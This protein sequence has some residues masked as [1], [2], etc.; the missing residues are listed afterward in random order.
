MVGV[1]VHHDGVDIDKLGKAV[2]AASVYIAGV[3]E[4]DT[5]VGGGDHGRFGLGHLGKFGGKAAARDKG[6]GAHDGKLGVDHL[7]RLH[8]ER[9]IE[10]AMA[11]AQ[12]PAQHD[13]IDRGHALV[14]II[15]DGD[16]GRDDRDAVALIEQAD[17]LERRG[18]GVDEHRVAVADELDGA[19]GN[20][21]L[22]GNVDVNTPVL[23]GD[24]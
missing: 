22:G 23:R 6:P 11:F 3:H 20:G 15:G 24:G 4:G 2:H 14:N 1:A 12:R 7:Q 19:L 16:I 10:I 18:A 5:L 17:E 8:G 13:D 21:L 9:A